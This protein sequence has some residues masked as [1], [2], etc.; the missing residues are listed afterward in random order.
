MHRRPPEDQV[1][2]NRSYSDNS[3]AREDDADRN[4][5]FTQRSRSIAQAYAGR[6]AAAERRWR[7]PPSLPV[8]LIKRAVRA[9]DGFDDFGKF[10]SF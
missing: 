6:H 4:R 1:T 7:V 9:C 3:V 5:L 10:G 2:E 8:L